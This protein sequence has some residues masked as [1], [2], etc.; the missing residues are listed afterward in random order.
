M[1]S[2]IK[3][4]DLLINSNK[5]TLY[6]PEYYQNIMDHF[7]REVKLSFDQ[8]SKFMEASTINELVWFE[9]FSNSEFNLAFD[10]DQKS[11]FLF[12][13][14]LS[15]ELFLSENLKD[16]SLNLFVKKLESIFKQSSFSWIKYI[17]WKNNLKEID[18]FYPG[19]L[20]EREIEIKKK[21]IHFMDS[22]KAPALEKLSNFSLDL[23]SKYELIRIHVLKFLAVVPCLDHD[24]SQQE[25]KSALLEMVDNLLDDQDKIKKKIYKSAIALP[26][27]YIL[28]FKVVK[29]LSIITPAFILTPLIKSII[30]FMAKRFIA[31]QNVKEAKNVLQSLIKT[32]RDATFDQLGELVITQNEA[33]YYKQRVL[34]TI[35]GFDDIY[36]LGEKNSAGILKAH[37]SIKVSALAYD[38][39]PYAY[40]YS[41]E[42]IAPRLEEIFDLAIRKKVFINIDAEHFEYRDCIWEIYKE[43]L[44]K[45]KYSSW[46]DTGIVLQ[47]YLK[48]AFNHFEEIQ[49]F[50]QERKI[51]MPIRLVKGA[52]WD[53][54]TVEAKAHSH[55]AP[56]FL[57]KVETDIHYRQLIFKILESDFLDLA[58]ASHNIHDHCYAE[59]LK[60]KFFPNK[61]IEHQ[62]LHMTFEALS[63][64][65]SKMNWATRNY[66][67]IG[68]LLIG[69]S[70]LVRRIMENSSQTGFLFHSRKENFSLLDF[71]PLR[72]LKT[73]QRSNTEDNLNMNMSFFSNPPIELFLADKNRNF[74]KSL[75]KVRT[76]L[77]L[78]FSNKAE[79]QKIYSPNDQTLVGQIDF[80]EAKDSS[81]II[82]N[83]QKAFVDSSWR[84]DKS[85]RFKAL[86]K[87]SELMRTQRDELSSLIIIESGKTAL[88]AYADVDEAIDFV[89]FY[90]R[91]Y[92]KIES[93]EVFAK[94]IGLIIAP[95][96]FP[97][98]IACGMSVASLVCGNATILKSSEKTPLIAQYFFELFSQTNTPDYIFQHAPGYGHSIGKE[99]ADD[100]RVS[101][102]TFT[103]S[104]KVGMELFK[105]SFSTYTH[106]IDGHTYKREVIAEMGGKNAIVVTSSC[107]IDETLSGVMYSAFAHAGQK[108][109]A[110]SRVFVHV[111]VF[112]PFIKRLKDALEVMSVGSSDDLASFVNPLITNFDKKRVLELIHHLKSILKDDQIL[113]DSKTLGESLISPFVF[114]TNLKEYEEQSIFQEEYFAP[115]LQVIKYHNLNQLSDKLGALNNTDYALTAGIYSQ[116][117]KQIDLITSKLEAGNIYVN[118]PNT[119]A[120]VGIEPFGGFKLSG[121]GPKAGSSSYLK[122]FCLLKNVEI[123]SVEEDRSDK[124]SSETSKFNEDDILNRIEHLQSVFKYQEIRS[125]GVF[126]A[127]Q[128]RIENHYIPGQQSY[129]NYEIKVLGAAIVTSAKEPSR[130]SL[131]WISAAYL[132]GIDQVIFSTNQANFDTLKNYFNFEGITIHLLSN[133]EIIKNLNKDDVDRIYIEGEGEF[134]NQFLKE[135]SPVKNE[136]MTKVYSSLSR[137]VFDEYDL[138]RIFKHERS[139]AVN[140]MRHG[141]P[142]GLN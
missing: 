19:D 66:V 16:E 24:K 75:N 36:E 100:P 78:N 72:Y 101:F 20:L 104:K 59:A 8:I 93:D 4:R 113:S 39:K 3:S 13:L 44:S 89:N 88:E 125:L 115:I 136:S 79:P 17:T 34:E 117:Y 54:E 137:L 64:A 103:G 128:M 41:Y 1:N 53:A 56:Q 73:Q 114:H 86:V 67:P 51:N 25:V 43:V 87:L 49:S 133:T 82:S 58:L 76:T 142:L 97:L 84:T 23:S 28:A 30:R 38:L 29:G 96:N 42:Q 47:A 132:M 52:Y 27:F 139:F 57:N 46:A 95:W 22:Y 37:A 11:C 94:G 118:R 110:C 69:M 80:L 130:E 111:S 12:S 48:D 108:C 14:R 123:N 127:N 50:S 40:E 15:Q 5:Y 63:F 2:M 129:N 102:I 31:G 112:K 116:S 140:T 33:E 32:N 106:L 138:L 90:L 71:D 99:L 77:P 141:A 26:M 120:R 121:T 61:K 74:S 62:C 105:K 65:L 126:L 9:C 134:I 85:L 18:D 131:L 70:Y 68:D 135:L 35:N 60:D 21:L 55:I 92:Q 83:A 119:G 45:D 107:E 81:E 124:A 122:S 98:A 109:S 91:E 10:K 7:S 6:Y